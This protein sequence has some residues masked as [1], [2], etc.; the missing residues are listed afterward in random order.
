MK[1]MHNIDTHLSVDACP[2]PLLSPIHDL[3]YVCLLCPNGSW[4][5]K[6]M[7]LLRD[8]NK[9]GA[10]RKGHHGAWSDR[11][12]YGQKMLWGKGNIAGGKDMIKHLVRVGERKRWV[13]QPKRPRA[14][15]RRGRERRLIEH[16]CHLCKWINWSRGVSAGLA[17][18]AWPG[19]RRRWGLEVHAMGVFARMGVGVHFLHGR[20]GRRVDPCRNQSST[21]AA[22]LGEI[23]VMCAPCLS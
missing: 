12:G 15:W 19:L 7:R 1:Y 14:M 18:K 20:L 5:R 16:L 23:Q 22:G 21:S 11:H 17:L 2:Y 3:G 6:P 8:D 13:V 10:S 9:S 4:S